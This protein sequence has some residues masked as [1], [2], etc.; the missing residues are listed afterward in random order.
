MAK[1]YDLAAELAIKANNYLFAA[2]AYE[3]HAS[4]WDSKG[5]SCLSETLAAN[6]IKYW[7]LWGC[8]EKIQQ[9]KAKFPKGAVLYASGGFMRSLSTKKV[10]PD[11]LSMPSLVSPINDECSDI[12]RKSPSRFSEGSG[13]SKSFTQHNLR[14]PID[15]DVNTVLQVAKTIANETDLDTLIDTI[16]DHLLRNTGS[17]KALFFLNEG[18]EL[19]LHSETDV[20]SEDEDLET[21]ESSMDERAPW[22]ILNYVKRTK[23]SQL[24]AE[25][26]TTGI[27]ATDAYLEQKKPKSIL[28]CPVKYQNN[29][30]GVI[31]LENKHQSNA[32]SPAA[33]DMV[34]SIMGS[35]SVSIENTRLNKKNLE[36]TEAL[37][38]DSENEDSTAPKYQIDAPI[39][40]AIESIKSVKERFRA[41]DP[42]IKTLDTILFTLASDGLFSADL[43]NSNDQHGKG[44]DL[45]TKD[46][47]Q[48]S[49]MQKSSI[50][51]PKEA[52]NKLKKNTSSRRPSLLTVGSFSRGIPT[53]I[54]DSKLSPLKLDE[55]GSYLM[56]SNTSEFD[57]FK[58]NDL[59]NGAP[60]YHLTTYVM[61]K[62]G[63]FAHFDLNE[64]YVHNFMEKIESSYH[65][66]PYHNR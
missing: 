63:L 34:K 21:S 9:V 19:K 39:Q 51:K 55:V 62:H 46:W 3:L 38:G 7:T 20:E 13:V 47:I 40:K 17:T 42:M 5:V 49:L 1:E 44:I 57:V 16:V 22:S 2:F 53:K 30:I 32:F 4:Y 37:M 64:A 48:T 27:F 31:Y 61:K 33:E 6:A 52:N 12:S 10:K 18:D 28:C 8:T 11:K 45:D 36:L 25:T 35:A 14:T 23:E 59:T 54:D 58:L 50:E 15:L 56:E 60:L 66:N 24:F 41:D 43:D 29:L 65:K 26:P